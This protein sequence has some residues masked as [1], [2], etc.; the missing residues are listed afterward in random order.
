[1]PWR[2]PSKKFAENSEEGTKRLE[3][4]EERGWDHAYGVLVSELM[5]QQTQYERGE[6]GRREAV[7]GGGKAWSGRRDAGRGREQGRKE[8][9]GRRKEKEND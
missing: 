8:E 3:E 7:E 9:G 6:R 2:K 1:L 4:W 5:L